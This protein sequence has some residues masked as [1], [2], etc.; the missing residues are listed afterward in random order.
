MPDY[1]SARHHLSS[2][3]EEKRMPHWIEPLKKNFSLFLI[4]T[5]F[6]AGALI[7]LVC[8]IPV[9]RIMHGYSYN[10]LVILIFMELFTNLIA[11]TGIMQ[12]TAVKLAERSKGERRSTLLWFGGLMFVISAF[13][14]NITAV[15]IILPV[16][17][18]LL[19]TIDVDKDYVNVFFAAILAMSNTGGAAS[20]IG[21][22]PAIVIMT[23]GIT[24]FL[25]YLFRALP[26]FSLTAVTLLVIWRFR[27]RS[28]NDDASI[29]ELAIRNLKSQYKNIGVRKDILVCL[30]VIFVGMFL[31][32]S[33]VP[34][35]KLPPEITAV[36]GYAAAMSICRF[37]GI[38]VKLK[39]DLNPVLT[40][41][42][43][44]FAAA[45]V[46]QTGVLDWIANSLQ[47]HIT[48]PKALAIVIM[49]ITAVAAGCFSAGPAAAAMM[50]II[51][52]I[53]NG[54]LKE[55][56]D[57]IAVAYAAA[58]CAGSSLFMWS[59]TAGFILSGKINESNLIGEDETPICWGSVQYL[60]YGI[61]NFTVQLLIAITAIAILV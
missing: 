34:P 41:A 29:R 27:V 35:E 18:V 15:M 1:E 42:A 57:L 38:P 50:P 37:K 48:N 58:I 21:D 10:V 32:W 45:A 14:N 31:A 3:E 40:I 8:R 17:F 22:F 59:A 24:S 25:G 60:K 61:I 44:L 55:Q 26:L 13:L 12:R 5:L 53:C 33:F 52:S 28:V 6:F 19:K 54:P 46:S 4:A 9:S 2:A 16:V 47:D 30:A 49:L 39:M 23:S 11:E 7:A 51:V 56:S 43:F 36:L 20:P